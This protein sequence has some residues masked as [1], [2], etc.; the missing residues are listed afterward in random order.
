LVFFI[1][2]WVI[3]LYFLR[4][5]EKGKTRVIRRIPGLDAVDECVGRSVEMGRPVL[6]STG[7]D[8]L[9]SVDITAIIVSF[10]VINYLAQ[11]TATAG[12]DLLLPVGSADTYP[13]IAENYR[14]GCTIAGYPEAFNEDNIFYFTKAQWAYTVG[15]LGLIERRKPGACIYISRY[16]AEALHFGI[17]ARKVGALSVGGTPSFGMTAFF[18]VTCDYIL[19]GDEI[20]AA[21]AY[22]SGDPARINNIAVND[23]VKW[24]IMGITLLGVVLASFGSSIIIDLL[25][26]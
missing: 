21:G 18:A 26:L 16:H 25:S 17:V 1:L 10:D 11:K 22:M 7:Y 19:L 6:T 5:S 3:I 2:F 23:V 8:P 14:D 15:V 20:Y 12:T 9:T 13:L 4:E 24:L